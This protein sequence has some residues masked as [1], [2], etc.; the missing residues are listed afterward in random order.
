MASCC[1]EPTM[2]ELERKEKNQERS[3]VTG[4]VKV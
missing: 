1:V 2:E 3:I 4:P